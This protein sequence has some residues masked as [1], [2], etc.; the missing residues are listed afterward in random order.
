MAILTPNVGNPTA[1]LSSSL[2]TPGYP[3]VTVPASNPLATPKAS[4][5]PDPTDTT[6]AARHDTAKTQSGHN[7]SDRSL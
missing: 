3:F 1:S 4:Q 2:I 5:T 6:Q 7:N